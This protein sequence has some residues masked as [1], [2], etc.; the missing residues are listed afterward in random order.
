[1]VALVGCA[2]ARKDYVAPMNPDPTSPPLFAGLNLGPELED[3][4]LALDPENVSAEEVAKILSQAPA[5]RIILIHGGRWPVYKHMV[6]FGKF[7][8]GMGYPGDRIRN[9]LDG[10]YSFSSYMNS[11][12][13]AGATA[14]YYEREG[15]RPML[16]GHS[17]G[18]FQ[19]VRL[20]NLFAGNLDEE[21]AL[22]SP[23]TEA[24]E[25]RVE[26]IDP[27]TDELT[28]VA[29]GM[30]VCLGSSVGGGGLTWVMPPT[31]S[32][33]GDLRD[34]PDSTDAFTGYYMGMDFVGGD[35]GGFGPANHFHAMGDAIIRNVQLPTGTAHA[36][37]PTTDHLLKSPEMIDWIYSY[38]PT[39][40][41]TL[42]VEFEGKSKNIL[43][44]ADAWH[45]IRKH[46][47]LELQ[48]VIREERASAN[49]ES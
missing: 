47:V 5:P 36:T 16:I 35:W 19:V 4:I 22:W 30:S 46:W 26:F 24:E 21:V 41:P 25:D 29:G 6:S 11:R 17:L 28:P 42:D 15:L 32:M 7:L 38:T 12:K 43:Y 39:N 9:P 37:V 45:D 27:V 23:L 48:R 13:V 20:L 14:W 10:T 18:S 2:T 40:Q 3:E 31:W 33:A 8:E 34:I 44:A 49:D 1:M